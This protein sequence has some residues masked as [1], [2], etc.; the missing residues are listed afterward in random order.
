MT[1]NLSGATDPVITFS[2]NSIDVT[3]GILKQGGTAV[4]LSGH[5]HAASDLA[6]GQ[7]ALARGGNASDLSGTGPGFLKQTTTGATV[8]VAVLSTGDIPDLLRPIN[9]STAI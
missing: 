9:R 8:T 1:A 3:T 6:S 5:M 7:V 4:S 2:N